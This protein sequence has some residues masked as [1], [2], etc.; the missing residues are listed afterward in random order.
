MPQLDHI[1]FGRKIVKVKFEPLKELD[2]YYETDKNII[3]LDSRIKGKRLFNTIIHEIFHMIVHHQKIK[4][5]EKSEEALA[6]QI[7]NNYT[8]IFKQNPKLWKFLTKLLKG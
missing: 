2:G 8:K 6:T 7:G 1:S 4:C 3:V 5:R